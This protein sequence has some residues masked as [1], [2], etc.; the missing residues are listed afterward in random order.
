MSTVIHEWS[1]TIEGQS[2][3]VREL[4]NQTD[5]RISFDK[6]VANSTQTEE[7]VTD[8]LAILEM[9]KHNEVR[10]NASNRTVDH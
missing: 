6:L 8:F 5:N 1:F 7:V 2:Q 9:A 10:L 4:L 3:R